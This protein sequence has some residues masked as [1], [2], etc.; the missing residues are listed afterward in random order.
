[1]STSK[2]PWI[3]WFTNDEATGKLAEMFAQAQK[4]GGKVFNI[5]R[6]M[7]QNPDVLEAAMTLYVKIM[8]GPSPLSRAQREML[9]TTV[10]RLN[11]CHY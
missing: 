2:R 4:R 11:L 7:G 6:I 8:F 10:S 1:M 9:A 5:V 3:S